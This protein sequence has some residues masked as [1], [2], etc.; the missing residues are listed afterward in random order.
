MVVYVLL[1]NELTSEVVFVSMALLNTLQVTL[2]HFFPQAI[3]F[4]AEVLITCKRI[5]KFLLLEEMASSWDSTLKEPTDPN[6]NNI[7]NSDQK[8]YV[9]PS[10][11]VDNISAKW[12]SVIGKRALKK[13]TKSLF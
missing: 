13:S 7:A 4:G 6:N 1:G 9:E 12:S 3:G 5:E 11:I 2:T 8:V 10:L